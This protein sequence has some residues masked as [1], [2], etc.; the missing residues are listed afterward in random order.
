MKKW[1]C[2]LLLFL[3]VGLVVAEE[4]P[5]TGIVSRDDAEKLKNGIDTYTPIDD[6]GK[7]DY[8]KY[9]PFVTKMDEK[10]ATINSWLDQNVGWMRYIF[11]MKPAIS[12]LFFINVYITIWFLIVLFFNAEGIWFFI[13]EKKGRMIF[14]GLLFFALMVAG[15]YYGIANVILSWGT[16]LWTTF[17]TSIFLLIIGLLLILLFGWLGLT[18][19][20]TI[21]AMIANYKLAK[22]EA[23]RVA[24]IATNTEAI[25]AFMGEVGK[26]N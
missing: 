2:L 17:V 20:A 23:K 6:S 26:D 22:A 12:F 1:F 10:I 13:E 19:P 14:G 9:K 24:D 18:V 15:L 4:M 8:G 16:Y 3:F 25:N 21:L 5:D 7:I 11:H